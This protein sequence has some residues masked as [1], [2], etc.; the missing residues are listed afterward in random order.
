[1][2]LFSKCVIVN[3][4]KEPIN[5]VSWIPK[6]D[7]KDGNYR[8][9]LNLKKSNIFLRFQHYKLESIKDAYELI[10][11]SCYFVSVDLKDAYYSILMHENCLKDLK[12]F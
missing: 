9:K 8:M 2:Y 3:T 1:M 10:T 7:Q 6:E 5:F 11:E 4:T 12:L